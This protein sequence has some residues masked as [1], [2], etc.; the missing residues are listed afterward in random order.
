MRCQINPPPTQP[1]PRFNCAGCHFVHKGFHHAF[2]CCN[3][4]CQLIGSLHIKRTAQS[5]TRIVA[6]N[7]A[8]A[9]RPFGRCRRSGTNFT[10]NHTAHYT[11]TNSL[12]FDRCVWCATS[13]RLV[14]T[15]RLATRWFCTTQ[16]QCTAIVSATCPTH[17]PP[18]QAA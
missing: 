7:F 18:V 4:W 8:A 13:T 1:A 5:P 11:T 6:R 15:T 14:V 12:D 9:S 10:F 17:L 2:F 3:L 16:S